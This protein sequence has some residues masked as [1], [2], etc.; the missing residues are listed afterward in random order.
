MRKISF[1]SI[2]II[3]TLLVLLI[4]C[5]A[6]MAP[7]GGPSD[8]TP[9]ELIL[10]NISDASVNTDPKQT[11]LFTFSEK[12]NSDVIKR[13]VSLFP[14]KENVF[15]VSYRNKTIAI[16]PVQSWE[17][18]TIY[19]LIFEKGI[20]DLR[21]NALR[22]PIQFTFSTGDQIPKNMIN[23]KIFNLPSNKTAKIFLSR[24][25]QNAP[26]IISKPEYF[27]QS[28]N[29]GNFSFSYM[30][31]DTFYI[32][33]YIDEDNSNSY[34]ETFDF[35][36]IPESEY[37]IPDTSGNTFRLQ[38]VPDN[39][40]QARLIRAQSISPWESELSFSKI[41]SDNTSK[42]NITLE[43]MSID[44]IIIKDK[45]ISLYHAEAK[46]SLLITYSGLNDQLNVELDDSSFY[47]MIEKWEND[48][49][50]FKQMETA[51]RVY[52][53]LGLKKL[54]GTFQSQD[55]TEISLTET[56]PGFYSLP[57]VKKEKKGK[58]ILDLSKNM[59]Q[60]TS[61]S[62]SIYNIDLK[63]PTKPEYGRVLAYC[64]EKQNPH[65]RFVLE[66][67]KQK[68]E[69]IAN[70]QDILFNEVLPGTYT[71]KYYVDKNADLRRNYGSL[72]PF[73]SPEFLFFLDENIDVKARWD[74]ELTDPFKIEIE[75]KKQ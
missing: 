71:L 3:C 67:K 4:G 41:L 75:N 48:Y 50:Q 6:E 61:S 21:S 64:Q 68:Y 22:A 53:H 36:C 10:Q 23:G 44:T 7:G 42:E 54:L 8:K 35:P 14:I 49:Y 12:L 1:V 52:P 20:S 70:G 34:K 25:V 28:D 24:V 27:T 13:N 60:E 74:T 57:E 51:L 37:I 9:P 43:G 73:K 19:T 16:S 17:D 15:D 58:L 45:T 59:V 18:S 40:A 55:T 31:A 72:T 46:D 38:A 62:D 26:Q 39:F 65:V 30:P 66:N 2:S 69:T 5:A 29:E 47:I 32:A 56:L 11:F 33:A 63:L